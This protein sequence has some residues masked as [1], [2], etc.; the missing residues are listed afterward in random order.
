V[1]RQREEKRGGKKAVSWY[2]AGAVHFTRHRRTG[3]T[4]P[5]IEAA[6]ISNEPL[7]RLLARLGTQPAGLDAAE[8]AI[9]VTLART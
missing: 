2:P 3:D 5:E 6:A 1:P 7:D 9:E 8:E 4:R